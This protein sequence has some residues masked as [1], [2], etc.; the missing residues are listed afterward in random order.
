MTP[1]IIFFDKGRWISMNKDSVEG[2]HMSVIAKSGQGLNSR[3][4]ST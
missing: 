1:V 3:S 2:D 4:L